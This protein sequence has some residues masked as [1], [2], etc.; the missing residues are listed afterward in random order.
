[1]Q[2]SWPTPGEP[3]PGEPGDA[4]SALLRV[5][6]DLPTIS[7]LA[8]HLLMAALLFVMVHSFVPREPNSPALGS[9]LS[10]ASPGWSASEAS[11]EAAEPVTRFLERGAVPLTMRLSGEAMPIIEPQRQVRT[12]TIVYTVQAGDSVLGIAGMFGLRGSSLLWANRSLADNPDFL[13][14]GQKLNVLPI[15]GVYHQVLRGD[16]LESIAKTYKVAPDSIS[17][18]RG[19]GLS[20]PFVLK[21]S[22]WLIVPGGI[23]PYIPKRV[24]VYSGEIPTGAKKGSGQF[25]WPVSGSI[26]QRYWEGHTA[27]D[28]AGAKGSTI[29]AA[30][31]GYVV[32]VQ[33]SDAGYGRAVTIDHGN[34]YQTLYAHMNTIAV[35]AAQSVAKGEAIGTRGSTGN[36]TG[37]HLHF[38]IRK[39]GLRRNPLGYLP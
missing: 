38:E 22:Q 12:S 37:P 32:N 3:W 26:S 9:W 1:M 34:G 11:D 39:S 21:T 27:I 28:I 17:S 16:T 24:T 14:I 8:G 36:S 15:D 20:Q 23:M 33:Y 19:N 29:V 13:L 31:S 25:A 6:R 10:I 35:A 4:P 30:D 5:W 2:V 18:Y 7:R